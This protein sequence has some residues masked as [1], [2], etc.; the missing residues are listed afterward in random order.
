MH[1]DALVSGKTGKEC[2]LQHVVNDISGCF[3]LK[4]M[5]CLGQHLGC[6]YMSVLASI[7]GTRVS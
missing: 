5:L 2:V 1:C 3:L 7:S 4:C 6:N